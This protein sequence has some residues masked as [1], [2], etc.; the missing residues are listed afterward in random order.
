VAS[1]IRGTI[2]RRIEMSPDG[3]VWVGG[4]NGLSRFKNGVWSPFGPQSTIT[5][6]MAINADTILYGS[7]DGRLRR[8]INGLDWDE[9]RMMPYESWPRQ[10]P[11]VADIVQTSEGN[12]WLTT[13]GSI[14]QFSRDSLN[15]ALIV[16]SDNSLLAE[17]E[18][19]ALAADSDNCLWIGTKSLGVCKWEVDQVMINQS[20]AIVFESE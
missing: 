20:R 8:I 2:V 10:M 15:E 16:L 18:I 4:N 1:G 9:R 11:T 6:I 17:R 13:Y 3:A 14:R 5:S 19:T 12:I 7:Y